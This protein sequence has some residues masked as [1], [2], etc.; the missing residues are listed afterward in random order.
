[1]PCFRSRSSTPVGPKNAF[2]VASWHAKP[3]SS[4]PRCARKHETGSRLKLT[5]HS[6]AQPSPNWSLTHDTTT[7]LFGRERAAQ[8]NASCPQRID[9]RRWLGKVIEADEHVVHAGGL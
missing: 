2:A 3:S 6:L 1:M 9:T 5:S 8:I 7:C 4:W